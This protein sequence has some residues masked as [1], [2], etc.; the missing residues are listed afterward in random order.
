MDKERLLLKF[1]IDSSPT[2]SF[3]YG[4]EVSHR[5]LIIYAHNTLFKRV[6]MAIFFSFTIALNSYTTLRAYKIKIT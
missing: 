2:L 4:G 5:Y 1:K 3:K 6:Q